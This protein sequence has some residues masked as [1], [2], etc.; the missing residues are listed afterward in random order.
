V[1]EEKRHFKKLKD[2]KKDKKDKKEKKG[3]E[4]MM[5][6]M[7][8]ASL[9][10][11][12]GFGHKLG[13]NEN[14]NDSSLGDW[15]SMGRSSVLNP[16]GDDIM[17]DRSDFGERELSNL[18]A[19][20]NDS[21]RDIG[22]NITEIEEEEHDG[23]SESDNDDSGVR[24]PVAELEGVGHFAHGSASNASLNSSSSTASMFSD[25]PPRSPLSAWLPEKQHD[26]YAIA[27]QEC[28]HKRAW[29]NALMIHL[30]AQP[31]KQ[32]MKE[33]SS[34]WVPEFAL[35]SSV[36][37]TNPSEIHLIIIIRSSLLPRVSKLATST[38]AT[39]IDIGVSRLGN[40]GS[41][42]VGFV[43]DESTRLAFVCSHLAARATRLKQRAENYADS[44][45]G[46]RLGGAHNA[47]G[48]GGSGDFLH[49]F[50]HCFWMG[51]LN[52]RVDLGK[53]GTEGEFNQ[54]LD[55]IHNKKDEGV[56]KLLDHDQLRR[57]MELQQA[58]PTA[59]GFKE[60]PVRW[61]PTYRMLK[62]EDP[63]AYSQKKFQNPS[64]TDRVLWRSA[65]S[66]Q[67]NVRHI[68]AT[69]DEEDL[70]QVHLDEE[71]GSRQLR[72]VSEV[73]R[74]R[75]D[76]AIEH[77]P[78]GEAARKRGERVAA[79]SYRAL[80][81]LNDSDHRPVSKSFGV[82]P[83]QALQ[84]D[85]D[86]RQVLLLGE[87]HLSFSH[88]QLLMPRPPPKD[89]DKK[90]EKDGGDLR[91]KR[92]RSASNLEAK[93]VEKMEE[94][95]VALS[96]MGPCQVEQALFSDVALE[97]DPLAAQKA[98]D[99]DGLHEV[100]AQNAAEESVLVTEVFRM[101]AEP[102]PKAPEEEEEDE[103]LEG[104]ER[105]AATVAAAAA[106]KAKAKEFCRAGIGYGNTGSYVNVG[107]RS[108]LTVRNGQQV[109]L[110]EN[111]NDD[112]E[113]DELEMPVEGV[114]VSLQ[115]L[116]HDM[117][118][119]WL[120]ELLDEILDEAYERDEHESERKA[121]EGAAKAGK[122]TL[123]QTNP[124]CPN[125]T[126]ARS[127]QRH[128]GHFMRDRDTRHFISYAGYMALVRR[129]AHGLRGVYDAHSTGESHRATEA[130]V[131]N[132]TGV[133]DEE[134]RKQSFKKAQ[135]RGSVLHDTA[136]RVDHKVLN[137]GST[138]GIMWVFMVSPATI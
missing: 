49:Q 50:D 96:F 120:E 18:S 30:G 4:S 14:P 20:S 113:H 84:L 91:E 89:K 121:T 133:Q 52:Y 40:K 22:E 93:T 132:R 29:L 71:G 134:L 39:G 66:A 117:P 33:K 86:D 62:G 64:Y 116:G 70:E 48:S 34:N 112:G 59:L 35:L 109:L 125:A 68:S 45:S 101:F 2:K 114:A 90:K 123:L 6:R 23:S 36:S 72:T 119:D 21:M 51:D 77:K 54:C 105:D 98:E 26:I 130:G 32:E 17:G 80:F 60:A 67:M 78:N 69:P 25:A 122:K 47:G 97:M 53:M 82:T 110:S 137:I 102:V 124:K 75:V 92:S 88:V 73:A 38:V 41:A 19:L 58:Y 100:M 104:G 16:V 127:L 28:P 95:A 7:S 136:T 27:L 135:A 74:T 57:E 24:S 87:A 76:S 85:A 111:I 12:V 42:G 138:Y 11:S 43:F 15:Q 79:A 129:V 8:M 31:T 63:H 106:V 128:N 5:P 9:G 83:Q 107:T 56:C 13:P 118:G 46:L 44:V 131:G 10:S 115:L 55:L 126:K 108:L 37:L 65:A 3:R 61:P 81:E 99:A 94:E 1:Y 103:A